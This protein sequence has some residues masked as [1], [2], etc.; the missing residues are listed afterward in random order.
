MSISANGTAPWSRSRKR[1]VSPSPPLGAE[2]VGVRWGIPQRSPIPTSPS[3]R[4]ALGPS[5]SALKGGEGSSSISADALLVPHRGAAGAAVLR[6]ALG[7]ADQRRLLRDAEPWPRGDLRPLEH[8]QLHAWRAVH[9]GRL[10]RLV[11]AELARHRLL[12]VPGQRAACRRP[13]LP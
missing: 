2:R 5:L 1:T 3:Q 11:S 9:A 4:C 12:A 10:L 8:H 6:A 7:R 13:H